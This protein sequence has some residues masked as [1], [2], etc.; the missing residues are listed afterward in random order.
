MEHLVKSL[1]FAG[2]ENWWRKGKQMADVLLEHCPRG[3]NRSRVHQPLFRTGG[4]EY[5]KWTGKQGTYTGKDGRYAVKSQL[6]LITWGYISHTLTL[7][8][9]RCHLKEIGKRMEAKDCYKKCWVLTRETKLLDQTKV[10]NNGLPTKN[11]FLEP[12]KKTKSVRNDSYICYAH[13][14]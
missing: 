11:F 3:K 2:R 12:T 10:Q 8:T 5:T 7:I 9:H 14:R 1:R 6:V 4:P 13:P